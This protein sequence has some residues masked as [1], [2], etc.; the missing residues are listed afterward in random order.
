M[1][2]EVKVKGEWIRIP[3]AKAVQ[4][5]KDRILRCNECW[6]RVRAHNEGVN[7][8]R[9]H[10]EHESRNP[11]CSLGDCYDGMPKKHRVSMT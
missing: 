8:A 10:F 4:L 6:G 7:G 2:C 3:I 9:A 1:D 11:G 5:H